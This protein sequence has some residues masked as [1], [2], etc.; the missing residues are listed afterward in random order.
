[1]YRKL[2]HPFISCMLLSASAQHNRHSC[3]QDAFSPPLLKATYQK[4]QPA[5]PLEYH[6]SVE[7]TRE[8]SERYMDCGYVA[9]GLRGNG[10]G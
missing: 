1:M 3:R 8:M 7:Y 6:T 5:D 9:C 4:R 10:C 2:H